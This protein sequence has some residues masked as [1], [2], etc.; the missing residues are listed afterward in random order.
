MACGE[1]YGS[2]VLARSAAEVIGVDANPEAHEHA[3]LRYRAANL[4]FERGLIE[5]FDAPCD[6]VVFLQTIEHVHDAD[7]VLE[8]FKS[9]VG[10][11]GVV[12]VTT[13]NLLTIAP[14]GAEKSD[15]PWHLREYR[16]GRVRRPLP[17]ALPPRSS[18]TACITR[19]APRPRR[20]PPARLGC[21]SQA[22]RPDRALLRPLHAG[23]LRRRLSIAPGRRRRARRGARLPRRAAP[24]TDP[25]EERHA[26]DRDDP[27]RP[28]WRSSSTRTCRMSR[29][30]GAG[31]SARSGSGRRSPAP[32][33]RCS[34]LLDSRRPA[35]PL[36]DAC[37]LR[38]AR[39]PRAGRPIPEL[40]RRVRRETHRIDAAAMRRPASSLL[41]AELERAAGD[42]EAALAGFEEI[43][44]DLLGR[45]AAH[46]TW[47]SSATHAVLPL[48]ATDAGARMQI[49]AGGSPPT[50]RGSETGAEASGCRSAPTRRGLTRCWRPPA[51]ARRAST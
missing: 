22:S 30:S 14:P 46:A 7:A 39:G 42:Y 47:T 50:A 4:R 20:R 26:L 44:G 5:T 33:C 15:N 17:G 23:D 3:R 25:T 38:P 10:P 35:D 16:L 28:T 32:I 18:F 31:R 2:A 19:Q 13:P 8:R 45:L 12:F 27:R 36:A 11:S 40:P 41:A 24:V 49:V 9:L 48:C 29:A 6:A 37:A 21:R 34:T 1:G 51:S 43:D